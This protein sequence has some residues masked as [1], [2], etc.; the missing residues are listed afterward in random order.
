[1]GIC[2]EWR[3]MKSPC[4]KCNIPLEARP[5]FDKDS[6][7]IKGIERREYRHPDGNGCSNPSVYSDWNKYKEW[8]E[9]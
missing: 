1:M 3:R 4:E 6:I 9:M 5:V 2:G 8:G 7:I